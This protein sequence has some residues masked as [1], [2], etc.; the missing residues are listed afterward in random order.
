MKAYLTPSAVTSAMALIIMSMTAVAMIFIFFIE[1]P[2]LRYM[3]LPFPVMQST[4]YAGDILPLSVSRC[5]EYDGRRVVTSSRYLEKTNGA[6]DLSALDMVAAVIPPG[7]VTQIVKIHRIPESTAP[8]NYRLRGATIVHGLIR[9]F[10]IDWSS[11]PFQVIA[12]PGGRP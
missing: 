1:K 3:N 4:V 7:C 6:D 9:D 12:K 2:A 10:E 11:E 5:S 8:G